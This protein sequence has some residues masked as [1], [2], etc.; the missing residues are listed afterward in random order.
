MEKAIIRSAEDLVNWYARR[1][2]A[3]VSLI[4]KLQYPYVLMWETRIGGE[5]DRVLT[6]TFDVFD[7]E[8]MLQE[9]QPK[10]TSH[11]RSV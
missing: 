5:A 4:H 3:A 2:G 10:T 1:S 6:A 9:L 7:L 8:Q 11:E